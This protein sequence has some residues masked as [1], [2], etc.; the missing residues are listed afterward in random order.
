M[1]LPPAGKTPPV[2]RVLAVAPLAALFLVGCGQPSEPAK[3]AAAI[4][5]LA[6]EGALLASDAAEGRSTT[7]FVRV[8]SLALAG[9]ASSLASV[10][11]GRTLGVLSR[12]VQA[13]LERL[14]DSAGDA[15]TARRLS[16]RLERETQAARRLSR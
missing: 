4:Q 10:V 8:Q 9:Q 6:A 2:R 11:E 13:D 16:R 5:S 12:R 15:K 3:E 7:P 1:T 14:S